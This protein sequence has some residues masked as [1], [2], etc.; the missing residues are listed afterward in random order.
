MFHARAHRWNSGFHGAV[1]AAEQGC[2]QHHS[3]PWRCVTSTPLRALWRATSGDSAD[4]GGDRSLVVRQTR[5]MVRCPQIDELD[6]NP[7]QY[8]LRE[9]STH[10]AVMVM[11]RQITVVF[12]R[13]LAV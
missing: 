6:R 4:G 3:L 2:F 10:L 9:N 8:T 5:L 12:V 11:L 13:G 1:R 7:M